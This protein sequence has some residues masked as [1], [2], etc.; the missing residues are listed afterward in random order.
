MAA[1]L[2]GLI[3]KGFCVANQNAAM[4]EVVNNKTMCE[5]IDKVMKGLDTSFPSALFSVFSFWIKI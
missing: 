3:L 2:A 1:L 5:S 4:S